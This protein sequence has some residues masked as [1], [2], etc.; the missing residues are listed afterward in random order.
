MA[1]ECASLQER[2]ATAK[3]MHQAV[4]PPV[5]AYSRIIGGNIQCLTDVG[6]GDGLMSA[7]IAGDIKPDRAILVDHGSDLAI[8]LGNNVRHMQLDVCADEFV[9]DLKERVH[10]LTCFFS[11]HE[12]KNPL[13]A[14]RNMMDV[15]PS[16]AALFIMDRSEEAWAGLKHMQR[17]RAD[18]LHYQRDL[19]TIARTGLGTDSGIRAFWQDRVAAFTGHSVRYIDNGTMYTVV[20]QKP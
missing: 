1:S 17:S 3:K 2:I 10:L 8:S 20:Y 13:F 19:K 14:A 16:G 4:G 6:C 5:L 11:F 18:E 7:M 12:F 15:L 9:R